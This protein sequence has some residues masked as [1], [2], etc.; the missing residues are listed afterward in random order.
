MRLVGHV[1]NKASD[2]FQAGKGLNGIGRKTV[3]PSKTTRH[4]KEP[5]M[6]RIPRNIKVATAIACTMLGST[7][8][9]ATE[10]IVAAP[11][12]TAGGVAGCPPP[13]AS[14]VQRRILSHADRGLPVLISFVHRTQPMYNLQVTDAVAVV[15]AERARRQGC[16]RLANASAAR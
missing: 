16:T 12:A 1:F 13:Y 4:F 7:V 3:A 5:A 11:E 15:E 10:V 6:I 9:S 8:A 2:R 14:H